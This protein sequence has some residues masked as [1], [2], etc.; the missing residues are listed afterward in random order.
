[1][2]TVRGDWGELYKL[3]VGQAYKYFLP[4]SDG[5]TVQIFV[6][7]NMDGVKVM[8]REELSKRGVKV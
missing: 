1:M 6:I 4:H 2:A 7:K 8:S 3:V 5:Y